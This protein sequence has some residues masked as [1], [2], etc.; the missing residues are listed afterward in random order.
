MASLKAVDSKL[1]ILRTWKVRSPLLKKMF[2]ILKKLRDLWVVEFLTY[3]GK[4]ED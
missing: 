3:H 2:I 1:L 4:L